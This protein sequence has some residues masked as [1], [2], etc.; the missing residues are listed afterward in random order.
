MP[1]DA[2]GDGTVDVR[3]TSAGNLIPSANASLDMGSFSNLFREIFTGNL[4]VAGNIESG[5]MTLDEDFFVNANF[6]V[7]DQTPANKAYRFRT[8]G[9]AL[10]FDAGGADMVISTY[11]NADFS[12]GQRF[13]SL[14]DSGSYVVKHMVGSGVGNGVRFVGNIFGGTDYLTIESGNVSMHLPLY[15]TDQVFISDNT[16]SSSNTTGAL[17]V[18]GGVGIGANLHVAGNVLV[19]GSISGT[20]SSDEDVAITSSTAST[21]SSTGALVVTGGIG[22][23]GT[24]VGGNDKVKIGYESGGDMDEGFIMF[25]QNGGN[26]DRRG[27]I[28]SDGANLQLG[29]DS[30]EDI[31][32]INDDP[33]DTFTLK[34]GYRLIV[35]DTTTSTSTS[36]GALV[37]AGGVG[38]GDNVNIGGNLTLSSNATFNGNLRVTGTIYGQVQGSLAS[39]ERGYFGDSGYETTL[40][41]YNLAVR[42]DDNTD[43]SMVVIS[44]SSY[45][46]IVLGTGTSEGLG[47]G[48]ATHT[49]SD[50]TSL[51]MFHE[52]GTSRSDR[53][54]ALGSGVERQTAT[55]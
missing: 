55:N 6:E 21:S 36:T 26:A 29:T 5:G 25:N 22:V 11:A 46:S 42:E 16:D 53:Y 31:V 35:D 18:T 43:G 17:V 8:S 20:I 2:D 54:L 30:N 47:I 15:A 24:V 51:I 12:G 41:D 34:S 49:G 10:D 40:D 1:I 3:V 38:I 48:L 4:H 28:G 7:R 37:V 13:Y 50:V 9:S 32:T 27:M 14:Y 33:N 45:A 39:N 23:T 19:A 44:R 52:R